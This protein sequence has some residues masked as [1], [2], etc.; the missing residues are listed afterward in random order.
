MKALLQNSQDKIIRIVPII[1]VGIIAIIFAFTFDIDDLRAFLDE[2]QTPGLIICLL[3]YVLLGL[4]IVPS[5]P[6]TLLVLAWKGP[7]IAI[8]LA[9]LGNTLAALAEFFI[10]GN[11]GDIANFEQQKE[12]L[13]FNLGKLPISSPVFLLLA[14]TLPALGPRFVNIAAGI[15]LVPIRTFLWTALVSNLVGAGIV[16]AAGLG[17]FKLIHIN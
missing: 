12:K 13:P 5:E 1:L 11:I 17:L 14:R 7:L 8:I 16:V 9:M 6:V 10:G 4:T 15:Y 3:V 2:Y